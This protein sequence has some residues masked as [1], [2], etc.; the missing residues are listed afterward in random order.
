[1]PFPTLGNPVPGITALEGARR[2]VNLTA[3]VRADIHWAS[4][5]KAGKP[6]LLSPVLAQDLWEDSPKSSVSG[7]G[8]EGQPM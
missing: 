2:W 6:V 5:T 8:C 1:M 7:P 4:L 3:V